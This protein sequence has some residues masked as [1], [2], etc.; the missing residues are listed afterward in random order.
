[1]KVHGSRV[2]AARGV[3]DPESPPTAAEQPISPDTR[4]GW[5]VIAVLTFAAVALLAALF[6]LPPAQH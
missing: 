5:A 4:L 2:A 3:T 1:V 6:W